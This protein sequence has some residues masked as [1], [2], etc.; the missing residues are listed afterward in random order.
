MIEDNS[1]KP[2]MESLKELANQ[3]HQERV[4]KTPDRIEYA[5]KRFEEENIKYTLKN[6]S[7]G[8][9][10]LRDSEDNLFQFWA[11]T[12]K[13]WFDKKTKDVRGFNSFYKDARGIEAC[14]KIVKYF[15]R[16]K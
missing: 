6:K 3:N 16:R 10:H 5:I 13:I 11:S 7:I 14:I 12:G 8:H 4:A 2:E 1:M 15:T 9:F